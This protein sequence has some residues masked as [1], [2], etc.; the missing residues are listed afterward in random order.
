M[1]RVS[2]RFSGGKLAVQDETGKQIVT[3][4]V[5]VYLVN[6]NDYPVALLDV[7]GTQAQVAVSAL[8]VPSALPVV[9]A[10]D[11]EILTEGLKRK[12]EGR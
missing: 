7:D 10:G 1:E 5:T 11:D 12:V 2:I 8:E 9:A 6:G 3:N 4:R